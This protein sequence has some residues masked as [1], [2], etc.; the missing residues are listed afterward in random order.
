MEE[1]KWLCFEFS[2]VNIQSGGFGGEEAVP[3]GMY[4][5]FVWGMPATA[6]FHY[7]KAREGLSDK[8]SL[9]MMAEQISKIQ[10][11]RQCGGDGLEDIGKH[12]N[13]TSSA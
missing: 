11:G 4:K 1:E 6:V 7:K 9:C 12:L 10:E 2:V 5:A 3:P 13:D 8:G